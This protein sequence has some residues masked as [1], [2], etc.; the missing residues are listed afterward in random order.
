[1]QLITWGYVSGIADIGNG[2][3]FSFP[4]EATQGQVCAVVGKWI[5]DHPERWTDTPGL[6]VATA[7]QS[8]FPLQKKRK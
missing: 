2:T 8:A 4:E 5:D 7:L 6:I 1:M 3:V